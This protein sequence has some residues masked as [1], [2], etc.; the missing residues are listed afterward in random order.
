MDA[1]EEQPMARLPYLDRDELPESARGLFDDMLAR[2]GRINKD[3]QKQRAD[4]ERSIKP[5]EVAIS[6]GSLIYMAL[7]YRS[8]QKWYLRL[9]LR[10]LENQPL[11]APFWLIR[12]EVVFDRMSG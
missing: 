2:F 9:T 11:C 8:D 6:I 7:R 4:F 12:Q 3:L 10:S 5:M 1:Q